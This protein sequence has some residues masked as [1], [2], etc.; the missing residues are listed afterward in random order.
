MTLTELQALH[1]A[2][3]NERAA[4]C[5][6]TKN[7]VEGDTWFWVDREGH[8]VELPVS[9]R[10]NLYNFIPDFT[11]SENPYLAPY[12]VSLLEAEIVRRGDYLTHKYADVLIKMIED[13]HPTGWCSSFAL[14]TATADLRTV[15][16]VYVLQQRE[17]K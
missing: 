7:Y 4:E 6:W 15:A 2:A 13:K 8:T 12:Y 5:L 3:L 11:G 17:E 14:L 16:A 10:G 9:E 1:P